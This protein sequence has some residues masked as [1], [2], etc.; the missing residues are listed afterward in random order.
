M[1]LTH[2][3]CSDR[4][5]LITCHFYIVALFLQG[6]LSLL[7]IPELIL[8]RKVPDSGVPL[9]TYSEDPYMKVAGYK[10]PFIR[11]DE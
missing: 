1:A 7:C 2:L 6:L 5:L 9:E 4:N 11:T 3:S 8:T 10:E